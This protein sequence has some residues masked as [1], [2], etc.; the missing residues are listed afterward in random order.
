MSYLQDYLYRTY[1]MKS[2]RVNYN[3]RKRSDVMLL[4]KW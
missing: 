4:E 2:I 1:L 3:D